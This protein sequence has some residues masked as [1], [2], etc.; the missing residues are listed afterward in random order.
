MKRTVGM[1]AVA[2]IVALVAAGCGGGG[3]SGSSS[4]PTATS[5]KT[6][7]A[8]SNA[9][10][11]MNE[12]TGLI[13]G[14]VPN[15]GASAKVISGSNIQCTGTYGGFEC[16]IWDDQGG[17]ATSSDHK[18]DITG[19]Y[20]QAFYAFDLA[21]ECYTFYPISDTM[22]DGNWTASITV[23]YNNLNAAAT[24]GDVNVVKQTAGSCDVSDV[25]NACDR[26]VNFDGGNCEVVCDGTTSC[27][28]A[29]AMTIVVWTVG[30]RGVTMTDACGTYEVETG[31]SSTMAF[32]MPSNSNFIMS[33]TINGTINGSSISESVDV[34]CTLTY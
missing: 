31:T 22:V 7:N 13:L 28:E 26:T 17:S 6:L 18:C 4:T 27:T 20:S 5:A 8:M 33:S 24:A 1:L 25:S 21:Y 16:V 19:T 10:Q 29:A 2:V 30:S 9:G 34:N 23:N 15:T 32:C 14:A 3:S 11:W 12:T